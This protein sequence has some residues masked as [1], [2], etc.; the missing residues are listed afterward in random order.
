MVA[1]IISCQHL[2]FWWAQTE[3]NETNMLCFYLGLDSELEMHDPSTMSAESNWPPSLQDFK[4]TPKP[5]IGLISA[6]ANKNPEVQA[7]NLA[8]RQNQSFKVSRQYVFET[9]M[10]LN[11]VWYLVQQKYV[12]DR[13]IV[14]RPH[15]G[16]LGFCWFEDRSWPG[17]EWFEHFWYS[18][19]RVDTASKCRF[20]QKV[21]ENIDHCY[22]T[23]YNSWTLKVNTVATA[24]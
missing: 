5:S 11:K 20:D 17:A 22:V 3:F 1:S 7:N 16:R 14:L 18:E 8:D 13:Q 10:M 9:E 6:A 15:L 23:S 4:T 21:I 19:G 12:T 2:M 24:L